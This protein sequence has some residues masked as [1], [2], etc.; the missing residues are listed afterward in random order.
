MAIDDTEPVM[1]IETALWD[2]TTRIIRGVWQSTA[3]DDPSQDRTIRPPQGAVPS[4]RET[5]LKTR[6][7]K[8]PVADFDLPNAD[9]DLLEIV[10]QGGMGVVYEARQVSIRRP[11]AVKILR[12]EAAADPHNRAS[13][14]SEAVV[15]G[16]LDHP[17][18]VPVHELAQ[19]RDGRLFFVMKRI[20]G[21]AWRST[22]TA[23]PLEENLDILFRVMD[24]VA[25]AHSRGVIHLDLKPENVMLGDFGEVILTDWGV[26]VVLEGNPHL[27]LPPQ[28][29][30]LGGTP[31]YMAPEMARG[32]LD[33]LGTHTD[34]YLL[35]G[36]LYEIITGLRPHGGH[37]VAECLVEAALN[38]IQPTQQRGELLDIARTAM[39]TRPRHRFRSVAAFRQALKHYLSHS[40]SL[41]LNRRAVSD[42]QAADIS[43]SYDDFSLAVF[44]FRQALKV[45]PDNAEAAENLSRAALAYAECARERGDL[46]L[47]LDQL[48]TGDPRHAD[49]R[50]KVE[51]T[52]AERVARKHRIKVLSRLTAALVAVVFVVLCAAFFW[53]RLEREG[54]IEARNAEAFHRSAAERERDRAQRELYRSGIR[55]ADRLSAGGRSADALEVLQ[56]LSPRFRGWEFGH[57]AARCRQV[58][59]VCRSVLKGHGAPV[60]GLAFSPDGKRVYSGS[61]DR[62]LRAWDPERGAA[63]QT[64]PSRIRWTGVPVVDPRGAWLASGS[65]E[66]WDL[67][68]GAV[69][70]VLEGTPSGV[71]NLAVSRNG[72]LLAGIDYDDKVCAWDPSTGR[73]RYTVPENGKPGPGIALSGDGRFLAY[74][75]RDGHLRL[76]NGADGTRLRTVPVDPGEIVGPVCFSPDGASVVAGSRGGCIKAFGAADGGV[77]LEFDRVGAAATVLLFTPDGRW[78]A[79]NCSD[80]TLRFW[81]AR[82]GK[83][84]AEAKGQSSVGIA[85]AISPDGHRL[86][87]GGYDL[88]VRVW[89]LRERRASSVLPGPR[90]VST[91]ARFLPDRQGIV[92]AGEDG[93]VRVRKPG[94]AAPEEL[95][96]IPGGARVLA[97]GRRTGCVAAAGAAEPIVWY[98]EPGAGK[99]VLRFTLPAYPDPQARVV[100]TALF[101]LPGDTRLAVGD[102]AGR[103]FL[104]DLPA[105]RWAKCGRFSGRPLTQVRASGD[106]ALQAWADDT[107][108]VFLLDSRTGTF[109]Q[110]AP[111][112]KN[113]HVSLGG[114]DFS[115]DGR[116]L[117]AARWD[118]TIS[119]YDIP[120]RSEIASL[121]GHTG[122]CTPVFSPDG[123]RLVSADVDGRLIVWDCDSGQTLLTIRGED[124]R[125]TS[126]EFSPNGRWLL[127]A[128]STG[129]VRIWDSSPAR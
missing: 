104:L 113:A 76:C 72:L 128:S 122:W 118:K 126:L 125:F 41:A 59:A 84:A 124:G 129:T 87:S 36:L 103:A 82:S 7:L 21:T 46:D 33:R 106:G 57:L 48:D 52:R 94:P 31:S 77:R 24:A 53:I 119:L 71:F 98:R 61:D 34:I 5:T 63:L 116:R 51:E 81:D 75:T 58:E 95:M 38:H 60:L 112:G 22:L 90:D 89:D 29:P 28:P 69:R 68:N 65:G 26:A 19:D 39:A 80:G 62:S 1:R 88:A 43:K 78:L 40:E 66:V 97:V 92:T 83:L 108:N 99:P 101:F 47:A 17:N 102:S 70:V 11:V 6:L 27:D 73:K 114:L 91:L 64:I 93:V 121:K 55:E 109:F 32:E 13:F 45:W 67:R 20:C 23:R 35:G 107:G 110:C 74:G 14:L 105:H 79:G 12:P 100:P 44:G 10:G 37:T 16:N 42:L 86:A 30:S 3:S 120:T 49:L 8:P 50:A 127:T 111:G 123:R 56:G 18:I 15:T 4:D 9:Y 117:A 54:A 25:F 85:L 96:R 2:E 115:P